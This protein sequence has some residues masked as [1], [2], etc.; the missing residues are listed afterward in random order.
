M[1]KLIKTLFVA[2]ICVSVITS[3]FAFA[4][5]G[6]KPAVVFGHTDYVRPTNERMTEE[7][8]AETQ[9]LRQKKY[10]DRQAKQE[11]NKDK[12]LEL[13][14]EFAP[15][16]VDDFEDAIDLAESLNS[17]ITN[18][19]EDHE[20]SDNEDVTRGTLTPE[21]AI[22]ELESL[23]PEKSKHKDEKP[24]DEEREAMKAEREAKR[25]AFQNAI[26]GNDED[27]IVEHLEDVLSNMQ[28]R[29][30]KLAELAEQLAN[31]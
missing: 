15:N 13:V 3:G 31:I 9:E 29:N 25:K 23:R 22:A 5:T 30:I 2:V 26:K 6:N 7:E 18:F 4:D 10:D 24:S 17:Q 8:K 20:P 19:M 12:L 28:E 11:E 14:N 16:L 21:E 27:I 1:N